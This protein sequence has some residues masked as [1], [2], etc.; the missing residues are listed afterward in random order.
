MKE[1]TR[2]SGLGTLATLIVA[3]CLVRGGVHSQQVEKSLSTPAPGHVRFLAVG[4]VNLGRSVG[5]AL[6]KGDTLFPFRSVRDTF[7]AYDLVFGN[8]ESSLSDQNGVTQHPVYNLIFCGPPEGAASLAQAGMRV[9]SVANNH[10]LDYGRRGLEQ[11]LAS[12]DEA[13]IAHAGA[14]RD[15]A[16]LYRP[17]RVKVGGLELA[18]FACTAIMNAAGERWKRAVAFADTG[19]LLPAVRRYRD[20]VDF[21]VVSY[22]GGTEYADRPDA[23]TRSFAHAVL[24]GGADLFLGHHPHVFYGIES[25]HGKYLVPS[26]GN[27]VFRQPARFWTQRSFALACELSRDSAGTR[28]TSLR[29]LPA[30]AGAQPRFVSEGEDAVSILERIEKL[31][32]TVVAEKRVW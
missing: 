28:V 30:L 18:F 12:L 31:S 16:G 14:A 9:V 7:A 22:H 13:G 21:I 2:F 23:S 26:L 24:D 10:L 32:T 4:D 25:W 1:S 5:Q 20:S 29:C 17:A 15:S 19:R 6:L 11:T 3:V 27:F 8:L